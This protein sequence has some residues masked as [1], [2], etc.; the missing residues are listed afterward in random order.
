MKHI[1][2]A[3]IILVAGFAYHF[4]IVERNYISKSQLAVI[5]TESFLQEQ[6]EAFYASKISEAD[7]RSNLE[8]LRSGLEDY[9][10]AGFIVFT[11]NGIAA[12]IER[13]ITSELI[14]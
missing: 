9:K 14:K 1:I 8:Y 2:T 10:N 5:D 11:A 12:G 4:G 3:L 6:T 13:D 7:F